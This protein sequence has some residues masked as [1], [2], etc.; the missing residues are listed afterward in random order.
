MI[1]Y[2]LNPYTVHQ[3]TDEINSQV[4]SLVLKDETGNVINV[5]NLHTDISLM[6][7]L[8]RSKNNSAPPVEE[9][10][11]PEVMTYR[12][13]TT[14]R[15]R[16]SIRISM[17]L[18]RDAPFEVYVKY[19]TRPTKNEFD[20]FATLEEGSCN[21][22]TLCNV[23]HHVWFDVKQKG[24]Y[25]IGLLQKESKRKVRRRRSVSG[26]ASSSN[27]APNNYVPRQRIARSLSQAN[28][29]DEQLC[30]KFK[31]PPK[32]QPMVRNITL[33][34]P[35]Y[36]PETSVNFT[37]EVDSA[38]CLFWSDVMQQWMGEGCRVRKN[39]IQLN[40]L[41]RAQPLL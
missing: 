5:S 41:L 19:G 33:A 18:T 3:P 9:Y 15:E 32:Q 14:H 24:K 38:G 36:D 2:K 1:N 31:D 20:F 39:K 7:P 10:S 6:V 21:N 28:E 30:V 12:V 26:I 29:S 8:K 27:D 11:V 34:M 37:L 4:V 13:V 35:P 22:K 17:A 23:S 40:R 16:T 25:F